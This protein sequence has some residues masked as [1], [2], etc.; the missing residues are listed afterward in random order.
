[1]ELKHVACENGVYTWR[2]KTDQEFKVYEYRYAHRMCWIIC[3]FMILLGALIIPMGPELFPPLLLTIG[4]IILIVLPL[5]RYLLNRPGFEVVPFR[6]TD[7]LISFR[8]GRGRTYI[9]FSRVIRVETERNRL[10]LYTKHTKYPVY[11]PEE[12]FAQMRDLI[13]RRVEDQG[14][15][16]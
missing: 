10:D 3:G 11:I 8:E 4:L 12:D 6:M 5:S 14:K 16:T 9:S 1:M 13:L 15:I 2:C 7:E